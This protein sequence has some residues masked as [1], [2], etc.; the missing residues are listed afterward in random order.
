[1]M[2]EITTR[3]RRMRVEREETRSHIATY[4]NCTTTLEIDGELPIDINRPI[5]ICQEESTND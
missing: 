4:I 2:Q 3:V 1:M 5:I